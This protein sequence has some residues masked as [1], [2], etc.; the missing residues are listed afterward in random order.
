MPTIIVMLLKV[1]ASL[2]ILAPHFWFVAER[3]AKPTRT[4][5]WLPND[6][7][8]NWAT[9]SSSPLNLLAFVTHGI[10]ELVARSLLK[11]FPSLAIECMDA[12]PGSSKQINKNKMQ[13]SA[14]CM[15]RSGSPGVDNHPDA[16]EPIG[17]LMQL[18]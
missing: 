6:M 9:G 12:Y 11:K 18:S 16:N 1:L 2:T 14:S 8:R 5:I 4:L 17:P 3:M 15:M 7:Q 10:T 13:W